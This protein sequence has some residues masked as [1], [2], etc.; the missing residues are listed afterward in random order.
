MISNKQHIQGWTLVEIAIIMIIIGLLLGGII[1]GGTLITNARIKN[2]ETTYENLARAIHTYQERYHN[3]PGDDNQADT[4]F[5]DVTG[6]GGTQIIYNGDGDGLIEGDYQNP[7]E[8][9]ET[10]KAWQHLRAAQLIIGSPSDISGPLNAFGGSTG[11]G[12]QEY[13]QTFIGFTRLPKAIADI[14]DEKKDDGIKTT[15]RVRQQ[16]HEDQDFFNVFF[17][18]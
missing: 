10:G 4:W 14:L 15:G 2:V 3:L 11:I 13:N 17:L 7:T 8:T 9:S 5:K 6:E 16:A 18:L 12:Y 1:K